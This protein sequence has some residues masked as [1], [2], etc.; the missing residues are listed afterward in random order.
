MTELESA[1]VRLGAELEFPETPDIAEAVRRRLAARP[2]Q[3]YSRLP[4]RRTLALVLVAVALALGAAFAV[5]PARSAILDLLGLSGA[6]VERVET[7]PQ[8]PLSTAAALALGEPVTLEEARGLASFGVLVPEELGAPDDVFHSSS[9]PGGRVSLVYRP[10]GGLSR[11]RYT[12]VGL[13]V[14]EF[15]GDLIPDFVGKLAGQ[16]TRIEELSVDGNPA[17]WLQG[18]PHAVTFGTPG[19]GIAEDTMRLAGNTLLL[20]RGTVLVR[21]EGSSDLSRERAIEIAQS[22]AANGQG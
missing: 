4:A 14:T 8:V 6:S 10:D 20:E 1:L 17:I 9:V 2:A 12:G 18:G 11:S 19:A 3:R 16:T 5:P 22:L 7:L 15:R 21:L 13:L